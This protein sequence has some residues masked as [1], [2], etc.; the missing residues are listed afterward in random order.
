MQIRTHLHALLY[1]IY[2]GFILYFINFA[3]IFGDNPRKEKNG[4]QAKDKEKGN[5]EEGRK[6]EEE[7]ITSSKF[8]VLLKVAVV[9]HRYFVFNSPSLYNFHA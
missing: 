1:S 7:E 8:F 2:T 5:K 4:R 9:I 3:M 6:E